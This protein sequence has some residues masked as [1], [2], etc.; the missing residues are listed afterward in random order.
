MCVR[1]GQSWDMAMDKKLEHS[2]NKIIGIN[3]ILVTVSW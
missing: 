2:K 1:K 3:L